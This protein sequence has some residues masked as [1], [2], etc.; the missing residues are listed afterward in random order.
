MFNKLIIVWL[1][2]Y[3]FLKRRI[4]KGLRVKDIVS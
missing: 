2:V 4:S 3:N 1:L